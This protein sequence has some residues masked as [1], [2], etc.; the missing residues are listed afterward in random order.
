MGS[1]T[2]IVKVEYFHKQHVTLSPVNLPVPQK[3]IFFKS[4]IAAPM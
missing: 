2:A 1:K 4:G 3:S